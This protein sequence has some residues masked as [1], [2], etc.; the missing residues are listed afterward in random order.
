MKK[1]RVAILSLILISMIMTLGLPVH[2]WSDIGVEYYDGV[3]EIYGEW[4]EADNTALEEHIGLWA[5]YLEIIFYID[6]VDQNA[7]VYKIRVDFDEADEGEAIQLWYRWGASGSYVYC[8]TIGPDPEDSY[9]TITDAS[10]T[11][12][13]IKIKDNTRSLDFDRDQWSFGGEPEL[14]MYWY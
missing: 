11:R 5:Y 6:N 3:T 2:A 1:I 9:F 14:W 12:L 13:Y 7:D 10:N 4:S 8:D